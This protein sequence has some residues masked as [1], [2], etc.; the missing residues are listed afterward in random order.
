MKRKLYLSLKRGIAFSSDFRRVR[1]ALGGYFLLHRALI[2][3]LDLAVLKAREQLG[4]SL[5]GVSFFVPEMISEAARNDWARTLLNE[6]EIFQVVARSGSGRFQIAILC[7]IDPRDLRTEPRPNCLNP[8]FRLEIRGRGPHVSEWDAADKERLAIKLS[9]FCRQTNEALYR[10]E[11]SEAP[12]VEWK[13]RQDFARSDARTRDKM[14]QLPRW[15][16][17]DK[18]NRRRLTRSSRLPTQE[19]QE[20]PYPLAEAMRSL[21]NPRLNYSYL[22]DPV[23]IAIARMKYLLSAAEGKPDSQCPRLLEKPYVSALDACVWESFRGLVGLVVLQRDIHITKRLEFL[24]LAAAAFPGSVSSRWFEGFRVKLIAECDCSSRKMD[25][26]TQMFADSLTRRPRRLTQQRV[27][28]ILEGV[29]LDLREWSYQTRESRPIASSAERTN[30][31]CALDPVFETFI[32]GIGANLPAFSEA[33]EK[34]H[35]AGM[36]ELLPSDDRVFV[37][38]FLA[39]ITRFPESFNDSSPTTNPFL[40]FQH[41]AEQHL[42]HALSLSKARSSGQ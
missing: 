3:S 29:R 34:L 31:L 36:L 33:R 2:G 38:R 15:H 21:G 14:K 39:A 28:N 40:L 7:S 9:E 41:R 32:N 19:E 30:T 6:L 5:R 22:F 20:Q 18:P 35:A 12:W 8:L 13:R 25:R 42:R 27:N 16:A 23:S 17:T 1:R 4:D 11:G 37:D 10:E 26:R 24:V